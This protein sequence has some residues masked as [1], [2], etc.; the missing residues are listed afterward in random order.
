VEEEC[1]EAVYWMELLPA[2]QTGDVPAIK[3]LIEE[4]GQILAIVVSS[5]QTA[6]RNR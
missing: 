5:I 1:D 3:A 6:R 2:T 4:S